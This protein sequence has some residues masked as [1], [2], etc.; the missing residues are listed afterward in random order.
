MVVGEVPRE[1]VARSI[2][3]R[4]DAGGTCIK[5]WARSMGSDISEKKARCLRRLLDDNFGTGRGGRQWLLHNL[6]RIITIAALERMFTRNDNRSRRD[7][8]R[9]RRSGGLE[10][11]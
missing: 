10:V 9:R 3:T 1:P 4:G 5:W 8:R 11:G 7:R 2:K 6:D